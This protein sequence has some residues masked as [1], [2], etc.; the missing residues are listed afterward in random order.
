[1]EDKLFSQ[2]DKQYTSMGDI[3]GISAG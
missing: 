1:M 2:I 3:Q